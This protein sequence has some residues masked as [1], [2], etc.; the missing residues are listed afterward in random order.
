MRG[1]KRSMVL[2][3]YPL[4]RHGYDRLPGIADSRQRCHPPRPRVL[5]SGFFQ[6]WLRPF[7]WA[8]GLFTLALFAF[9]AAVYLTVEA[10]GGRSLAG[11]FCRRALI[12]GSVVGA[13]AWVSLHLAR[14]GAP[15][16]FLGLTASRWALPFQ[17]AV[18]VAAIGALAALWW[19]R[20]RLARTAAVVQVILI[21]V[22]WALA[23]YPYL[24]VPD[25]TLD[26]T[27]AEPAVLRML[28][29]VFGVGN[30]FIVPAFWYLFRTFKK[31]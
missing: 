7:P 30:V 2:E 11:D 19:R 14:E 21:L 22:G 9:L 16:L 29:A 5:I 20:Y 4:P 3:V 26:R 27:S 24:V 31:S 1:E 25:L 10:G 23:Q 15:R 8:I 18:A 12:S 28:L 6:P 13:L 17:L